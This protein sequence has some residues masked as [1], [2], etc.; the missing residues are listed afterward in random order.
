MKITKSDLQ[1]IIKEEAVRLFKIQKLEE[2]Q[3]KVQKEL[4]L[5]SEGKKQMSDEELNELLA[6]LKSVFA[7]G[8]QK[9]GQAV[10]GAAQ[11]IGQA[12]AG[13]GDKAKEVGGKIA[14]KYKEGETASKKVKMEKRRDEIVAKIKEL[15]NEYKTITGKRY[16]MVGQKTD[17]VKM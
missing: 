3:I 15:A 12:V 7:A 5:I 17:A 16:S 14:T 13:A 10:A 1:E 6:G 8:A 11:K 4:K 2:A 9:A